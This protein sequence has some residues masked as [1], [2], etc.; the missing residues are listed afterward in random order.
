[1]NIMKVSKISAITIFT[2]NMKNSC[3]FYSNIPKFEL[4]YGGPD[5][6]FST[7]RISESPEMF[8]NIELSTSNLKNENI[9]DN[10]YCR[11]IFHTEDVDALYYYLRNDDTVSNLGKFETK[12][13][14]A[15]WGERF[16]QMQDPDGY[17]IVFATPISKND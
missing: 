12:P 1:M 5:T 13:T 8:L 10:D 2:K 6:N 15:E 11:I 17:P 4:T 14:D 3:M 16:F 7:F 9:S